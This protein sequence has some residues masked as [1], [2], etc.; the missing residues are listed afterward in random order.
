M[1]VRAYGTLRLRRADCPDI[2]SRSLGLAQKQQDFG[3]KELF[4]AGC[5]AFAQ[6]GYEKSMPPFDCEIVLRE[7]D[8]ESR[9]PH[10]F[11]DEI[12]PG[13]IVRI[14]DQD[15]VVIEVRNKQAPQIVCR[16]VYERL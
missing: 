7:N 8:H 3:P 9:Q 15:W 16:L 5:K 4:Y 12:R 1:T 10:S 14:E 11:M 2:A 13:T 6:N